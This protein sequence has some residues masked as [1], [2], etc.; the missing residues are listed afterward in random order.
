MPD[1]LPLAELSRTLAVVQEG[2]AEGLHTG[3]QMFASIAGR[4]VADLA[5]GDSREAAMGQSAVAM[6]TDSIAL[7]LSSTKPVVAAVVMQLVESGR[8]ELDRP[9]AD[10]I[11]PFAAGGKESITL[12]HLLTHTGGFRAVDVGWPET[13]WDEIIARICRAK[14]ERDWVVGQKAGYHPSS[15]WYILGELVRIAAGQPLPEYVRQHVFEPLYMHDCWIGMPRE[16]WLSYGDRMTKLIDTERP[17]HAPFRFANEQGATD[18]IPGGNGVGPMRELVAF[19]EML[20][21]GGERG[22]VRVLSAESV[23][24]MT[25]R[26]REG[27]FDETFKHTIDWGLGL[28]IDS[29]RYGVDNVPYGYGRYASDSTFGHGGSQSSVGFA[30]PTRQLA[31]ACYFNGMPGE[32]AHQARMRATLDA[33]YEDLGLV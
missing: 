20:L 15:S 27:M 33:L 9:V 2:I 25:T 16:R 6:T 10:W 5:L 26:Q 23:R 13:T 1:A 12:R 4:P 32:A 11:P 19:Y 18:C 24:L 7:W 29:K 21:G 17:R 3:C 30:D 31:V 14:V 28:I 22:G 8:L